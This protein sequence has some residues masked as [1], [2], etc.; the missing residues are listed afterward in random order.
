[1]AK[2]KRHTPQPDPDHLP[3]GCSRCAKCGRPWLTEQMTPHRG[4]AICFPCEEAF[5]MFKANLE[6]EAAR[7]AYWVAQEKAGL[8]KLV[9]LN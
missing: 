7:Q 3:P 8:D 5:Q 6:H 1:M 2:K 4:G 9:K